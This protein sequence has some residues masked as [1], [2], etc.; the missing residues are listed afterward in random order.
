MQILADVL[1]MPI[2]C[3]DSTQ[4]TA[5][6]SAIIGAVAAECYKTVRDASDAMRCP[7]AKTY[8]PSEVSHEEYEKIYEKYKKLCRYFTNEGAEIMEFLS[9]NRK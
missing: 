5:I 6:G 1:D 9:H 8:Y 2:N 4:A 3:L 7:I